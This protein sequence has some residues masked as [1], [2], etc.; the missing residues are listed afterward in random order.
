[1]AAPP[2]EVPPPRELLG[3]QTSTRGPCR[4]ARGSTRFNARGTFLDCKFAQK[5]PMNWPRTIERQSP[6]AASTS[7]RMTAPVPYPLPVGIADSRDTGRPT[8]DASF[9]I[10]TKRLVKEFKGFRAVNG[11]DLKIRRGTVHAL[12][13]PNGAGKT[14][15]FNLLTKF[16]KP[17]S[18]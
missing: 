3:P 18:G 15:C 10:E 8:P 1:M 2:A 9:V 17:S 7:E 12:I 4:L 6:R 11:V 16:L 13:G 14:T 5:F